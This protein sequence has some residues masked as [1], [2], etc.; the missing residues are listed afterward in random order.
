MALYY[1]VL[2]YL[3]KFRK[4]KVSAICCLFF[5]CIKITVKYVRLGVIKLDVIYEDS[6]RIRPVE[7]NGIFS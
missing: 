1:R 5:N 4:V 6:N 2:K 7:I 3:N